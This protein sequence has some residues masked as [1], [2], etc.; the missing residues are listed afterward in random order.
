MKRADPRGLP[1]PLVEAVTK[2]PGNWEVNEIRDGSGRT[3]NINH[4]MFVPLDD[5][6]CQC[7]KSH[8]DMIRAHELL[9]AKL[10]PDKAR[11]VSVMVGTEKVKVSADNI[12][13]AEEYRVNFSLMLVEGH[14]KM[15]DMFCPDP[16]NTGVKALMDSGK[17]EDIIRL[18]IGGG[19]SYHDY[20][21]RG[22][23][24]YEDEL[25]V[26]QKGLAK[27]SNPAIAKVMTRKMEVAINLRYALE[28]YAAVAFRIMS[29]SAV[30]RPRRGHPKKLPSWSATREL[31][32]FLEMNLRPLRDEVN[33]LFTREEGEDDDLKEILVGDEDADFTPSITPKKGKGGVYAE[34][35]GSGIDG[36][37]RWGKVSKTTTAKLSQSLPPWKVQR[38]NR[39]VD[40]G[41]IPRY[42]HRWYVDQRV[43]H[44]V[45]K[46][47]GGS[48]LIDDSGSMGLDSE[49][50][51]EMIEAA[52][53]S[54]VAVYAG[55]DGSDG[56]EIRVVAKDG[57]RAKAEDLSIGNYGGNGID[58]PALEWL[59]QQPYPR[60]WIT[61]GGVTAVSDHS[62]RRLHQEAA[63]ICRRLKITVVPNAEEA[64]ERLRTG[65]F[66]R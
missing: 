20:I 64:A 3:D 8:N 9:H 12:E 19:P 10:S 6:L 57:K 15:T 56:G 18:A 2:H 46:T 23:Q 11:A 32:A 25:M 51:D 50:L 59:G 52:P 58:G 17:Y 16:V 54:I 62:Y 36:P 63:D 27:D 28:E 7:G 37:I 38:K 26:A 13:A 55:N 21:Q 30:M 66:A 53:A 42:M 31:A 29:N 39:A 22:L 43:F 5:Y 48:V 41:T 1:S 24:A 34:P 45:K 65:K 60:I 4:R 35:G 44:R 47:S 14:L 49:D 61:D 40:E 33:R